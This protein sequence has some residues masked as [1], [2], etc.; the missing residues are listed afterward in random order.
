MR[1][2]PISDTVPSLRDA[3]SSPP[4]SSPA[5]TGSAGSWFSSPISDA[6][7]L[8]QHR[9]QQV[10]QRDRRSRMVKISSLI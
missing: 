3:Q 2:G 9:A 10:E 1:T 7:A 4:S 5:T 8:G 6:I